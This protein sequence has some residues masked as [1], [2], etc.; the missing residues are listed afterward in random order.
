MAGGTIERHEQ[1]GFP[2]LVLLVVPGYPS[3]SIGSSSR[4]FLVPFRCWLRGNLTGRLRAMSELVKTARAGR[5]SPSPSRFVVR[6]SWT[7][8]DD[9]V[10]HVAIWRQSPHRMSEV[11]LLAIH[12]PARSSLRPGAGDYLRPVGDGE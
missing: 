11:R 8:L 7:P 5:Y 2:P 10:G 3:R 4:R 1:L 6:V 12:F 9:G